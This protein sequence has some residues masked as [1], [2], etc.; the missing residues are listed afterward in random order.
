MEAVQEIEMSP[1]TQENSYCYSL[2][3]LFPPVQGHRQREGEQK[4]SEGRQRTDRKKRGTEREK[5][6]RKECGG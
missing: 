4:E 2:I 6:T 1:C 5:G 3:Y